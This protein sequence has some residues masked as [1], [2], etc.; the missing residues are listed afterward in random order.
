MGA[1]R[2]SY[3]SISTP[4]LGQFARNTGAS[5]LSSLSK[6]IFTEEAPN[7]SDREVLQENRLFEINNEVRTL[8]SNLEK[9]SE[10]IKDEDEA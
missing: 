9:S 10:N 3:K 8:L 6:G 4:E 2:R 5:E 1:R 7:Y